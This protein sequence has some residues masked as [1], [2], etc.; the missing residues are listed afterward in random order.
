[1]ETRGHGLAGYLMIWEFRVR[2][3]MERQ[4]E[5]AY[6]PEGRW[7]QLFRKSRGYVRT[8]MNRDAKE[9]R[10]YIT[11]DFW[12]SR[13][14]YR[15]FREVCRTEYAAIDGDCEQLTESE[16]EVGRFERVLPDC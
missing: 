3:G 6:G 2:P 12:V 9:P 7:V 14:A 5:E 15:K 13:E 11:L 16:T 1:M 8:E 10:R 4:F